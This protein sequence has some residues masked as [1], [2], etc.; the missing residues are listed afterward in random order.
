[1]RFALVRRSDPVC[2]PTCPEWISAEGTITR[3][4]P[5]RLRRLLDEI[6]DRRL[7]IVISSP[8]GDLP[9]ALAAG[10]L[11]RER[12]LDVAVARTRFVGCRPATEGCAAENGMFVGTA[13]DSEG[14]CSAACP[15]MLAG[16]VRRL[17]GPNAR[18]MIHSMGSE[19]IVA[20]YL[21]K[22]QSNRRC[23]P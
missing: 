4:T 1:M 14:E 7:P 17:V 19:L 9:G 12:G 5:E 3:T 21:E 16:G 15:L 13:V 8:G 11:I 18:L 10:R 20:E 2:E 22:W 23:S 6:G